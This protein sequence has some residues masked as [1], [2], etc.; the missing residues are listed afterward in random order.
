MKPKGDVRVIGIV[1]ALHKPSIEIALRSVVAAL[2]ERGINM[3]L[4][5]ECAELVG[6]HSCSAHQ[7]DIASSDMIFALGGD[8]CILSAVRMAAKHGTPIFGVRVGGLGFL[9]EVDWQDVEWA[10]EMIL[11]GEHLIESRR[12]FQAVVHR[13][14]QTVWLNYGLNDVVVSR[15]ALSQVPMFEVRINGELLMA[16][17]ADGVIVATPTGSTAY[18][19]SAG[20]P[21]VT[22]D[23]DVFIINPICAHSLHVRPV[24][25]SQSVEVSIRISEMKAMP[26]DVTVMVDGQLTLKLL[27]DDEVYVKASEYKANLVRLRKFDF[28]GR[29]R[30][31]LKWGYK[32]EP[33]IKQRGGVA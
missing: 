7:D 10:L 2:D 8:G 29:L 32:E 9:S 22:P 6:K 15:G 20:G 19:L 23:A 31:K 17:L 33:I 24:V 30:Q 4:T 11:N 3:L 1:A 26:M 14:G 12:L 25:T 18:S 28:L 21:I 16:E 5:S 13:E 27:K